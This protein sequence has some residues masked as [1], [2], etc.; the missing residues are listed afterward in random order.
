MDQTVGRTVVGLQDD[1]LEARV[2]Y[3]SATGATQVSDMSYM[4]RLGLWCAGAQ[5]AVQGE[6]AHL[7]GQPQI[8]FS[9]TAASARRF[10]CILYLAGATLRRRIHCIVQTYFLTLQHVLSPS[11]LPSTLHLPHLPFDPLPRS[12][13]S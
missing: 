9:F 7:P 4:T 12:S 10:S 2:V 13:H 6:Q 3:L 8:G 1:F 11:P 5:G